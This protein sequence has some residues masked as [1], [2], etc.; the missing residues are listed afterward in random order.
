MLK[1]KHFM[2]LVLAVNMISIIMYPSLFIARG[3]RNTWIL[4][5]IASLLVFVYGFIIFNISKRTNSYDFIQICY[6]VLGKFLGKLYL[7]LFSILLISALVESASVNSSTI[8]SNIFLETPVWYCI[9]IFSIAGFLIGKNNFNT[10]VAIILVSMT[11]SIITIIIIFLLTYRYNDFNQLLP[12]F[13]KK[14]DIDYVYC[15]LEQLGSLCTFVLLLPIMSKVTD[16]E[17]LKKHSLITIILISVIVIW[18]MIG[19][20]ATFGPIRGQNIY[21]PIFLQSQRIYYGGFVENGELF[22]LLFSTPMWMC[23]YILCI[24][25]L[26]AIWKIKNKKWFVFFLSIVVYILSYLSANNIYT[27]F[28]LLKYYQYVLLV[29]LFIIPLFIYI[30]YGIR[31]KNKK[32]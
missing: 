9:I 10:V 12:I 2:F 7:I 26:T 20:I 19:V 15:I 18:V 21:Y 14:Y 16:K 8:H 11:V 5:V 23:K 6:R 4:T 25:S 1:S 29:L 28:N 22:L 27:L 24:C 13:Q 30:C 17:N 3:G 31:F 32:I